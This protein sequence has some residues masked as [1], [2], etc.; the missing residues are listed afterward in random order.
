VSLAILTGRAG[1]AAAL[2]REV[3]PPSFL[4]VPP[5]IA[6]SAAPF[7]TFAALG[8]PNDS[9]AR[10][11]PDVQRAIETLLPP[12]DRET[13]HLQWVVR[14][15]TLAFATPPPAWLGSLRS[16]GDYLLEAQQAAV[17]GDSAKA[18]RIL[19]DMLKA[20]IGFPPEDFA[21]DAVYPTSR[22]R[23]TL[24]DSLG[25]G[26]ALDQALD[27]LPRSAPQ[28]S[29]D[30]A[31]VGTILRAGALRAELASKAGDHATAER[32]AKAVLIIWSDAD[33]FLQPVV[34]RLRKISVETRDRSYQPTK[35]GP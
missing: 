12:D 5:Q 16:G 32:W 8:G 17:R 30:P 2:A 35:E 6:R 14:P 34:D 3:L 10:L 22:L 15:A 11:L 18:R 33:P 29:D 27:A 26:Q 23:V 31:A 21:M 25:A 4:G 19:R 7:F 24:G 28:L 9:L 20:I 13:A 1:L